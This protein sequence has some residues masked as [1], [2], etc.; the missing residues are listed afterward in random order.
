MGELQKSKIESK[1]G[2]DREKEV[3]KR[4]VRKIRE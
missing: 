2:Y 1:K 3:R 4:T